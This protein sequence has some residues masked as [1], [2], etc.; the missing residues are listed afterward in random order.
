M[1]FLRKPKARVTHRGAEGPGGRAGRPKERTAPGPSRSSRLWG[2]PATW[3]LGPRGPSCLRSPGYLSRV[4][5]RV[6]L[7]TPGVDVSEPR[8]ST[9]LPRLP[10]TKLT[11]L[12][13]HPRP[14][15]GPLR[16]VLPGCM[17]GGNAS[18]RWRH[19]TRASLPKSI[20]PEAPP[21]EPFL[22][23]AGPKGRSWGR[24]W[25]RRAKRAPDKLAGGG[26]CGAGCLQRALSR[27][28]S[29]CRCCPCL[30]CRPAGLWST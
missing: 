21:A 20:L 15:P 9:H 23:P 4:F 13:P 25:G 29:R 22:P 19:R 3:P 12:G 2:R 17:P 14:G 7:W 16:R 24:E 1:W 18:V 26:E 5:A 28:R 10:R 27:A 8:E 30:R 6:F 11:S